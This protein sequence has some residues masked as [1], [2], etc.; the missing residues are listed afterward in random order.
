M[1]FSRLQQVYAKYFPVVLNVRPGQLL[2]I[3]EEVGDG[4]NTRT[5]KFK[6]LVI[7]TW[8]SGHPNG[9]FTVRGSS[10]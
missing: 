2:E 3:H 5:R 8:K 10:A 4:D 1:N 9:T 6:G 7:K